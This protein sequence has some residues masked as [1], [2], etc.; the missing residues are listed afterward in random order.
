M[1]SSPLGVFEAAAYRGIQIFAKFEV[2]RGVYVV[3]F[4]R[5]EDKIKKLDNI[6]D[7]IGSI[8]AFNAL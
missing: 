2:S 3:Q 7:M 8:I 1:K 5:K 6:S 4:M